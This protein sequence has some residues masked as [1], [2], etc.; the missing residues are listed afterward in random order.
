MSGRLAACGPVPAEHHLRQRSGPRLVPAR[1]GRRSRSPPGADQE[2]DGP[3]L[4]PAAL[5]G[6]PGSVCEPEGR[7]SADQ[8]PGP[9]DARL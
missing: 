2:P 8:G 7:L 5:R 1:H 9:G 6:V 3:Q 4:P